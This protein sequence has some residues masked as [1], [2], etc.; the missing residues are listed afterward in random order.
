MSRIVRPLPLLAAVLAFLGACPGCEA[1][2]QKGLTD[3]AKRER[4]DVMYREY[5]ESFPD[6][7][8]VTVSE[9]LA[10]QE[11][12]EVVLVDTREPRECEVSMIPGAIPLEQF[13]R[14]LDRYWQSPIVFYCTI[15]QRSGLETRKYRRQK[16]RAFNLKGSIL[17]WA[18]A[19]QKVVNAGGETRKVHVYGP[20]W[21]LLPQ[22]YEGV[23]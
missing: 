5:A 15:G 20:T 7:P 1:D 3:A 18:H 22:G 23:W 9:L 10:M 13:Q 17:S 2:G 14:D 19:G 4:I 12:E 16:L 6:A 11:K 8:A 21:D